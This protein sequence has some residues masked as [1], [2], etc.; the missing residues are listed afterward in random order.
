VYGMYRH[1]V[2]INYIGVGREGEGEGL[3]EKG[4]V[5]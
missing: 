1:I 4:N 5:K 2:G 3:G